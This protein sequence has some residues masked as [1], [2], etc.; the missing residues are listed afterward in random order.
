MPARSPVPPTGD[1][2]SV[3]LPGRGRRRPSTAACGGQE[4]RPN[5]NH[6]PVHHHPEHQ[7]PSQTRNLRI[8]EATSAAS[9]NFSA[10]S[11]SSTRPPPRAPQSSSAKCSPSPR[12][13]ARSRPNPI[14][15][16]AAREQPG[17]QLIDRVPTWSMTGW[18]RPRRSAAEQPVGRGGGLGMATDAHASTGNL[19]W[20]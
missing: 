2:S 1:P 20:A 16:T 10:R 15:D 11:P 12:A 6:R 13:T 4:R 19:L 7:D 18:A 3:A 5:A 17:E 14:R 8:W 9:T